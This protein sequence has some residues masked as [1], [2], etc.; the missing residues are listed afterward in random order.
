MMMMMDCQLLVM[1]ATAVAVLISFPIS[2]FT[3][4]D[5]VGVV[6]VVLNNDDG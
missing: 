4:K 2:V 1:V 6:S 3:A 5:D